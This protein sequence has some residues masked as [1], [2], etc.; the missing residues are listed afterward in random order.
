MVAGRTR[1]AISNRSTVS[2][3]EAAMAAAH[4]TQGSW[5]TASNPRLDRAPAP[6]GASADYR[7]HERRDGPRVA[8]RLAGKL[9]SADGFLHPDCTVLDLSR[10]GA[11]VHISA[12]IRL[13]PPAAL[14]LV[15][16]GLLFDAAVAWRRGNETGLV[17]TSRHDL[18]ISEPRE[19][20]GLRDLWLSW[21]GA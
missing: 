20:P 17:F 21:T 3:Y 2:V 12:A 16:E 6:P 14:L 7:G 4:A 19:R 18:R 8:T 5:D 15:D 13:P 9:I 1:A 11:R 10:N